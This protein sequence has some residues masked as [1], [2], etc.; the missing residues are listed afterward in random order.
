MIQFKDTLILNMLKNDG[1]KLVNILGFV[2]NIIYDSV[3]TENFVST[4]KSMTVY[5]MQ[6]CKIWAAISS[7]VC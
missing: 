1:R 7:G 2:I 4:L 5:S 6:Y 3:R